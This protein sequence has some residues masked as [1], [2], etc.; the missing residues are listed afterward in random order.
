MDNEQPNYSSTPAEI[1]QYYDSHLNLTLRELSNMT[2]HSVAYLK[3]LLMHPEKVKSW[4]NNSL[5]VRHTAQHTSAHHGLALCA[6][7]VVGFGLLRVQTTIQN[8]RVKND[9]RKQN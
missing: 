5:V 4:K 8:L 6:G 2:G 3:G 9:T 1:V 7:F